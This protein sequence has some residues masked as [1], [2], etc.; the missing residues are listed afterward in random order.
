MSIETNCPGCGT[1]V[2]VPE[3]LLG[4]RVKC[5]SCTMIFTAEA[6]AAAF[7]E[8]PEDEPRPTKSRRPAPPDDDDD[9]LDDYGERRPR[10][11]W[12][13]PHRGTMILVFGILSLVIQCFPLGIAA[14]VMGN[15]DLAAMRRGEMDREGEGTTQAGRICGM[16][17]TILVL[18]GCVGYGLLG[19]LMAMGGAHR[20]R[21]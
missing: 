7:E 18:L 13:Q 16:I 1:K 6:P 8:V 5:P 9:E 15:T 19:I 4:K 14:W 17:G 10:R 21:F 2:R 11:R 3:S 20:G 12:R